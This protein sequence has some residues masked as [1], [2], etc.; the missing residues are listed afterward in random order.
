MLSFTQF[1][2]SKGAAVAMVLFACLFLIGL[3]YLKLLSKEE[4]EG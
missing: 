2:F 1:N 4:E 3:F